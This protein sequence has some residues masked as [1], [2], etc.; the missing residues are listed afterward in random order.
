M[1]QSKVLE[2]EMLKL[3]RMKHVGEQFET[4]PLESPVPI[5]GKLYVQHSTKGKDAAGLRRRQEAGRWSA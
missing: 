1:E 4:V 3:E 2:E 5:P